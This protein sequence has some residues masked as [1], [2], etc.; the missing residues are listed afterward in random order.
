MQQRGIGHRERCGPSQQMEDVQRNAPSLKVCHAL[1][2]PGPTKDAGACKVSHETGAVQA[3]CKVLESCSDFQNCR[4]PPSSFPRSLQVLRSTGTH[5][6]VNQV[7]AASPNCKAD[8]YWRH[9]CHRQPIRARRHR[10]PLCHTGSC[11][12]RDPLM[13]RIP[14]N[15]RPRVFKAA[16]APCASML[17]RISTY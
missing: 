14:G 15:R 6:S 16:R 13:R 7:A 9:T 12:P 5:R 4:R 2:Q 1:H 10:K 17:Q 3:D 8:F 11:T